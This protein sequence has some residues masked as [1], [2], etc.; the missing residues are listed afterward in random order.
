MTCEVK[1]TGLRSFKQV[2]M[3]FF[4]TGT[5]QDDFQADGTLHSDNDIE[6]RV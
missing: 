5:I 3:V 4:G 2:T 6:K 1:A